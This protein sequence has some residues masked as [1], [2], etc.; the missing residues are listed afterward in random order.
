MKQRMNETEIYRAVGE[1]IAVRRNELKFTQDYVAKKVGLSRASLANIETGRQKII[2]HYLYRIA[3]VLELP[4][5]QELLPALTQAIDLRD[6]EL[7]I[8]GDEINDKQRAQVEAFVAGAL[9][10]RRGARGKA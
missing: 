1:A 4:R 7:S 2:L 5:V 9:P 10:K 8:G 6:A 3:A